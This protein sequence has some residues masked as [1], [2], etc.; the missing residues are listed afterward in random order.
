MQNIQMNPRSG[1]ILPTVDNPLE[2]GN[3]HDDAERRD[4]IICGRISIELSD[5]VTQLTHV[6]SRHW[7]RGREEEE[8]RSQCDVRKADLANKPTH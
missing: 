4:T 8:N 7:Q 2:R 1:E 5:S 3:D 6:A